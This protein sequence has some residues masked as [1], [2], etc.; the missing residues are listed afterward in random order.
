MKVDTFSVTGEGI[1]SLCFYMEGRLENMNRFIPS[2]LQ[3][4]YSFRSSIRRYSSG[5][6]EL[7]MLRRSSLLHRLL[8]PQGDSQLALLE[9]VYTCQIDCKHAGTLRLNLAPRTYNHFGMPEDDSPLF[10]ALA[11]P[12]CPVL[13]RKIADGYSEGVLFESRCQAHPL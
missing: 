5:P 6:E 1:A 7:C 11:H 12:L 4:P 10:K 13:R 9:T 8:R 2:E 3:R